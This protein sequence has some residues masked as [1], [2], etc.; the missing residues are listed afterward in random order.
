MIPGSLRDSFSSL[1][2]VG[3]ALACVALAVV[4]SG[5]VSAP[6]RAALVRRTFTFETDTFAYPNE[7]V[8]EYHFDPATGKV[9]TSNR[10]PP[11]TYSHH[12]FVVVRSTARFFLHAHFDPSQPVADEATYGHLIREVLSRS[13]RRQS[14][15]AERIVI[16][17]YANLRAFSA[18]HEKLLK[19]ECGGA[20]QS[21]LQRGHWRMIFPFSGGH[22]EDTARELWSAVRNGHAP[23]VHVIRF[24]DLRINHALLV[25]G[26]TPSLHEIRFDVY[27]PNRPEQPSTLTFHR[28]SRT[29]TFPPNPYFPGGPVDVYQIYRDLWH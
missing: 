21:Y 12:C 6:E 11:P 26:A 20:W 5:C 2:S 3:R 10:E 22:Q 24:P 4:A 18:A 25:F 7:L 27:D 14:A 1:N 17:G 13:P 19:A 28:D 29:F 23:I 16:P 9:T 8:W 15:E